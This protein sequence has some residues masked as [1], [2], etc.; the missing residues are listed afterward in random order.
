MTVLSAGDKGAH[1]ELL[2]CAEA[3]A[4]G[5]TIFTPLV[6]SPKADICLK[7]GQG[8]YIGIQVKR[9]CFNTQADGLYKVRTSSRTRYSAG[10]FDV[11]AAYLP[12]LHEFVFWHLAEVAH[13]GQISYSPVR[14]RAPGNWSLLGALAESSTANR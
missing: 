6:G 12:D 9:A 2:F 4:R 10:D 5:Y 3:G 1:A 14:H 8:P 11:L 7:M 13:Y